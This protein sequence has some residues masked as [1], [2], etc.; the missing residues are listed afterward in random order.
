MKR[1]KIVSAEEWLY[2][3]YYA[4]PIVKDLYPFWKEKF[5][6]VVS[7]GVSE[8]I[9]YGG[10]G[11]GKTYFANV[12]LLRKL[13]ELACLG[14]EVYE[15]LG[16]A[17]GSGIYFIY[18][19]VNLV[20]ARF[21]G[22][23]DLKNMVDSIPFFQY[24]FPRDKSVESFLRF[25]YNICVL[26][27]SRFQHQIGMN[28][29][30][31]VLDEANFRLAKDE[32]EDAMR[33]YSAITAR[34]LSRFVKDGRD[35]GISVLISSAKSPSAFVERRIQEAKSRDSVKVICVRSF[36]V[37]RDRYV[38]EDFY[39]FLGK[40]YL[41]PRLVDS[42]ADLKDICMGLGVWKEEY[43]CE[44]YSVEYVIERLLGEEERVLF[45]KVPG[46]FR[47]MFE[48]DIV[49]AI[50][51]LIGYGVSDENKFMRSVELFE[52]AL[53]GENLFSRE[54]IELSM[55][56]EMMLWD[57]FDVKKV[58]D[59]EKPRCIHVDLSLRRDR[60]GIACAYVEGVKEVEGQR[61]PVVRV[62]WMVAVERSMRYRADDEI[63]FWKIREF[64]RW[65]RV[66]G[67]NVK[68]VTFDKFQSADTVQLLR[69]DGFDAGELSVDKDERVYLNLLT[70]YVEGRIKHPY[71]ELYRRELFSLVYDRTK[72]ERKKVDHPPGGSKDLTDAVAGA[73][74]TV[75]HEFNVGVLN[76]EE[77]VERQRMSRYERGL[78]DILLEDAM[79]KRRG[80]WWE[81]F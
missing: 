44:S 39:V 70:L 17:S 10:I 41:K 68:K 25:P 34:R 59:K 22:F 50:R 76:I 74:Y 37:K 65:L 81:I 61:L 20:Q 32:F 1:R 52:R 13:Y 2:S 77:F 35:L 11:G 60:T 63:P 18:F 9:L 46:T 64:L 78:F 27:G 55:Y 69:R 28:V 26:A 19:S 53:D 23:Q 79:R 12:L 4:G 57:W 24:E 7:S 72:R 54:I 75:V 48:D 31:A 16:L 15:E 73:V 36:E 43:E 38:G 62:E 40:G 45:V 66:Q 21:T 49:V 8:V 33:L 30:G 80:N 29:L 42:F 67:V 3:G 71:V 5:I 58:K 6:E 14:D 47:R 56:D 51:D